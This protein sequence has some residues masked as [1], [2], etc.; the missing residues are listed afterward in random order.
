MSKPRRWSRCRRSGPSCKTTNTIALSDL[1][2]V[3][4]ALTH[5][6][7]RV[8]RFTRSPS[9]VMD[10]IQEKHQLAGF[11]TQNVA[12]AETDRRKTNRR[13]LS[14]PFYDMKQRM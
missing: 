11:D 5:L 13:G 10:Q 6:E 3:F 4:S 1:L 14:K 7:R 12:S 2:A 9:T 8:A